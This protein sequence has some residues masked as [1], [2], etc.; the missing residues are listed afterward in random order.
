[1]SES[2]GVYQVVMLNGLEERPMPDVMATLDIPKGTAHSRMRRAKQV[3][4]EALEEQEA[5]GR[6]A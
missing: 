2:E 1:M 4:R 6:A 5:K 3:L